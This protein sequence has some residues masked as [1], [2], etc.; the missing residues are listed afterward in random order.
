MCKFDLKQNPSALLRT[1]V[2]VEFVYVLQSL[3][4]WERSRELWMLCMMSSKVSDIEHGRKYTSRSWRSIWT[5]VLSSR[6]ATLPKK[7]CTSTRT[8]AN[9]YTT[10]HFHNSEQ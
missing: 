3:L 5:F 10:F 8:Y 2:N 7:A 9:R 4:M 1:C 6:R